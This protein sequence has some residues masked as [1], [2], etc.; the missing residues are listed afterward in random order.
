MEQQS[1]I[2]NLALKQL[3]LKN[4]ESALAMVQ[5]ISGDANSVRNLELIK[6][7][8][9]VELGKILDARRS[10][11]KEIEKFPDNT[12]A[13]ELL[14]QVNEGGARVESAIG[15]STTN[16]TLASEL[17]RTFLHGQRLFAESNFTEALQE[18]NRAKAMRAPVEGLDHL[19]GLVFLKLQRIG[20]ALEAFR[21]ELRFFPQN[22]DCKR[23]LDTLAAQTQSQV[24]LVGDEEF[25]QL[26]TKI[27]P[28]TML[29]S[30]RLWSLFSLAKTICE[31]NIPGNF[32]E[33]GVAA[34]GSSA[35]LAYV[36]GKYSKQTRWLFSFDSFSGMPPSSAIDKH[37]DISA[38][39]TG[40]GTGTC[41]APETSM[42][43]I[44]GI[45]GV[46]NYIRPVKG[47]FED[48]LP[49]WRDR[50]GM[51]SLLHL[52]GDWYAST[53]SILNN[54]YDNIVDGG[55]L[56]V[57]D[58][59]YWEGCRRA[60]H[61]FEAQRGVH[62]SLTVIDSTGVWF[63]K[64]DKFPVNPVFPRIVIDEFRHDD[65]VQHGIVSQMSDNERFQ[66]YYSLRTY[67]SPA[68][69]ARFIEV[70]SFSGASFLLSY[71][72][73]RRVFNEVK[74]WAVEPG[75]QPQFYEVMGVLNN[76]ATHLKM[77]SHPASEVLH[78]EFEKEGTLA[79][80]I[81]IDGDHSYGGVKQDIIDY[82]PLLAPG[83]LMGF[84]DFL[85]TL[86]V[87]NRESIFFHHA[88]QEPG[89]R[90]ACIELM[91]H[92]Y[93]AEH[94]DVPLLMPSNPTQTQPHLPIIPGVFST[95]RLYRKPV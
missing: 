44:C 68:Q 91:E 46:A 48:T 75:G 22:V 47:L 52:D 94:L 81:F 6:A 78:R 25:Q 60:I 30:E 83:G 24:L 66:L 2:I 73:L 65:P 86:T 32:V 59:G 20:D 1:N 45:L 34:G 89:I 49:A 56:Q 42:L 50:V 31:S 16:K 67:L 41:A 37:C 35:L 14:V 39:D 43:S 18:V 77:L 23:D 55:F 71:M 17:N 69:F 70:G 53:K 90:Q 38:E 13:M 36:I 28:Y 79:S 9:Y 54:L 12:S 76:D 85:P 3:E 74:G 7:M 82:Y 58:Y 84:H 63:E 11:E 88:N 8:C 33:C 51:L 40:W 92:T 21:E 57:D 4:V 10:L 29:S 19:R 72:A 80:F 64:P 5:S 61:E 95:F 27:R 26:L 62:F 87:H 15:A 93:R